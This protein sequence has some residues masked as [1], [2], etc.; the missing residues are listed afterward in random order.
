[1]LDEGLCDCRDCGEPAPRYGT[2]GYCRSCHRERLAEGNEA[3]RC[4]PALLSLLKKDA[5]ALGLKEERVLTVL[6]P[7]NGKHVALDLLV[8]IVDGRP[9]ELGRHL[10]TEETHD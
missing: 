4:T 7:V 8:A 3:R 9:V 2:S 1:M 5:L 10:H 6:V